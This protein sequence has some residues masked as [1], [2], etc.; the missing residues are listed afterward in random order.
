MPPDTPSEAI[1][2]WR[3]KDPALTLSQIG[4]KVGR[5]ERTVRRI[6]DNAST[7]ALQPPSSPAGPAQPHINGAT[8]DD[9]A[10]PVVSR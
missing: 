2:W 7:D 3:A 5:S 8:V 1:V 6:F 9:L 10:D 4:A